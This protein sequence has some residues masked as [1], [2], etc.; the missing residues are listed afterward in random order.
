MPIAI[1]PSLSAINRRSDSADFAA[2]VRAAVAPDPDN[3]LIVVVLG[4][5]HFSFGDQA[6]TQSRI[7]RS[8]LARM[9]GLGGVKPRTGLA[10]TRRYL[11]GFFDV[12]FRRWHLRPSAW[13]EFW[14]RTG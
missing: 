10:I 9:S 5:H 4:A 3:N 2:E 7:L 12:H 1:V 11:S 6:L 14:N 13:A 8:V